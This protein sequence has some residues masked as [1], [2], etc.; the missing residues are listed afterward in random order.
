MERG[1]ASSFD[2]ALTDSGRTVRARRLDR[3]AGPRPVDFSTTDRYT[4]L[5]GGPVRTRWTTPIPE[6]T[7]VAGRPHPGPTGATW[8]L[9]D[10]PFTYIEGGFVSGSVTRNVAPPVT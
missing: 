8:R 4:D 6:W 5:P 2:V 1:E 7:T 10:G 9:A 3:R